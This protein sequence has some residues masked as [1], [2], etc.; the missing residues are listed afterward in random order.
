ME[1]SEVN[2]QNKIKTIT[3]SSRKQK[4]R[5]HPKRFVKT[6]GAMPLLQFIIFKKKVL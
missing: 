5:P 1:N 3:F 4:S 6:L 2:R